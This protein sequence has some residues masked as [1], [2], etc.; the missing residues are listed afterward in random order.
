ML[1]ASNSAPEPPSSSLL[2][3]EFVSARSELSGNLGSLIY[4]IRCL[5]CARAVHRLCLQW[6]DLLFTAFNIS[7]V[8]HPKRCSPQNSRRHLNCSSYEKEG[9]R[10]YSSDSFVLLK[11]FT[12]NNFISYVILESWYI[13]LSLRGHIIFCDIQITGERMCNSDMMLVARNGVR[14][15]LSHVFTSMCSS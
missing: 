10:K 6:K 12:G 9:G 11:F 13:F 4:C 8:L 14:S 1:Q 3:L 7:E 5:P 15:I 2:S